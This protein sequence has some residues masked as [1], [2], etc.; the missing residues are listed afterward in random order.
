M[1]IEM[2][3]HAHH[4]EQGEVNTFIELSA[5]NRPQASSILTAL[6]TVQLY[7]TYTVQGNSRGR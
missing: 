3:K 1:N 7:Y 6:H 4:F 5:H 2:H